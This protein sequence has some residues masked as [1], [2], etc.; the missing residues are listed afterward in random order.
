MAFGD[1]TVKGFFAYVGLWVTIRYLGNVDDERM[2][3]EKY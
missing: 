2:A 1:M 3:D